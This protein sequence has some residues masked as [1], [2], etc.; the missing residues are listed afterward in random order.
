MAVK[1]SLLT[2]DLK[3]ARELLMNTDVGDPGFLNN[4]L[5]IV[6]IGAKQ[7]ELAFEAA[8]GN[9]MKAGFEDDAIDLML[10]ANQWELAAQ[11]LIRVNRISEAAL[12]CR[13]QKDSAAKTDLVRILARRMLDAGM[14]GYAV[15]LLSEIRDFATIKKVFVDAGESGQAA[16][17]A[18]S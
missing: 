5:K 9:L 7:R 11:T 3:F 10:L 16:L 1:C 17:I 15:V 2:N 13:S 6:V 12:I 8:V 4:M 14:V 18:A